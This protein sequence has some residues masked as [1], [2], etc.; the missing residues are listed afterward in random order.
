MLFR[1]LGNEVEADY[2]KGEGIYAVGATDGKTSAVLIANT[3]KSERLS[4]L[5]L[6]LEALFV[7]A[8]DGV[9][10]FQH[11]LKVLRVVHFLSLIHI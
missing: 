5:A 11:L 7:A 6:F 10:K 4:R 1:S 3:G 8:E 9:T 2:T